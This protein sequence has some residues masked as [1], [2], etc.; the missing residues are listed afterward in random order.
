MIHIVQPHTANDRHLTLRQRAQNCFHS[1]H[2]ICDG[3]LAGRVV[4]IIA[5]DDAR[6]D[7]VGFCD[8]A[9]VDAVLHEGFAAEDPAVGGFEADESFPREL[10]CLYEVILGEGER[11]VEDTL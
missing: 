9:E 6:L 2:I 3:R 11:S 5:G 8:E 10:H 7:L 4:D 1:H